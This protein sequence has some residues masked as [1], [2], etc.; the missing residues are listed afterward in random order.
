MKIKLGLRGTSD[1][2]NAIIIKI[3]DLTKDV[4][5]LITDFAEDDEVEETTPQEC[6]WQFLFVVA[7]NDDDRA[8]LGFHDPV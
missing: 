4:A 6:V 2:V 3:D 8:V 5:L 7:G 1:A